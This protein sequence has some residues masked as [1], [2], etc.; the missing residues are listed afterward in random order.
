M[1]ENEMDF[2]GR[3]AAPEYTPEDTEIENSLRPKQL[4]DYIGQTKA[5]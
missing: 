3:L 2:E 1:I 4:T 5:K